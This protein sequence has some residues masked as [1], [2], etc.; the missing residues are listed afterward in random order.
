MDGH[1]RKDMRKY[2]DEKF[3]PRMKS[4]K[5]RMVY[6]ECNDL[7]LD[8]IKPQLRPGEKQVIA[9][10]QDKSLFYANEYKQNIWCTPE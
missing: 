4:F 6:W 7:K 2:Q 9:V 3:L 8:C 1:E 5:R 10:F